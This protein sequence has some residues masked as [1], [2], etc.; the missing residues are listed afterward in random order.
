MWG[1]SEGAGFWRSGRW[2]KVSE[3]SL[4]LLL[5]DRWLRRPRYQVPEAR[6]QTGDATGLDDHGLLAGR[7]HAELQTWDDIGRPGT[8]GLGSWTQD[9]L[10]WCSRD[11]R[12]S[13]RCFLAPSRGKGAGYSGRRQRHLGDRRRHR[14]L[15]VSRCSTARPSVRRARPPS[16]G[17]VFRRS[18][19]NSLS[20][21]ARLTSVRGFTLSRGSSTDWGAIGASLCSNR[22]VVRARWLS[23]RFLSWKS[24]RKAGFS[25]IRTSSLIL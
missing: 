14:S 4:V 13:R 18:G 3:E 11:P 21:G 25:A 7:Q 6:L 2:G 12:S 8:G 15:G 16:L 22:S 1:Q 9:S 23:L 5:E 20:G 10:T 24:S 17:L 19:R